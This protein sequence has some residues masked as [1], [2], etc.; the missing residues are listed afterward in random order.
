VNLITVRAGV[1]DDLGADAPACV[2][3]KRI[4]HARDPSGSLA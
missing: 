1:A 3:R 2:G 4:P